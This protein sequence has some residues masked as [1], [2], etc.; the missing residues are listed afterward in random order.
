MLVLTRYLQEKI[1]IG[2]NIEIVV[3]GIQGKQARLGIDA[4]E[5]VKILR[6]ELID[7]TKTQIKIKR[8][9]LKKEELNEES[10]LGLGNIG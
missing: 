3:L 8:S 1:L 7:G 6:K 5:D 9:K 10:T 2:E 4:P